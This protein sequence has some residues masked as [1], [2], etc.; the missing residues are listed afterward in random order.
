MQGLPPGAGLQGVST[1]L[2]ALA[3]LGAFIR[4][5]GGLCWLHAGRLVR[6]N[7][8]GHLPGGVCVCNAPRAMASW[9]QLHGAFRSWCLPLMQAPQRSSLLHMSSLAL[10]Q[11][12]PGSSFKVT[13]QT[14]H[15]DGL[16]RVYG[17]VKTDIYYIQLSAIQ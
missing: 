11:T 14:S 3:V 5:L 4:T 6:R 12:R 15:Q 2:W 8:E 9:M 13:E 17:S 10:P 7:P 16:F 1:V